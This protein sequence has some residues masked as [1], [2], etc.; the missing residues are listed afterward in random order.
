MMDSHK[1][2][3]TLEGVGVWGWSD[4]VCVGCIRV[5]TVLLKFIS[6][7]NSKIH[8]NTFKISVPTKVIDHGVSPMV[9]ENYC[10]RRQASALVVVADGS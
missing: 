5:C 1:L 3:Q 7:K 4:R 10:E 6:D 9:E 8:K 2:K